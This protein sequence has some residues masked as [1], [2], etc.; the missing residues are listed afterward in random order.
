VLKR[1]EIDTNHFK[2]NYPD[3]ASLDGCL[4]ST[5][6]TIEELTAIRAGS[7]A[8]Q[9][10]WVE[11]LPRMKLKPHNRHFFSREL[12]SPGPLSHVRLNIFPD[13]GISR[14]RVH[15]IVASA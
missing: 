6:A 4:A 9:T 15:G 2:G 1:I 14:L 13:G 5:G 12:R 8:G 11:I 10:N 3:M 7:A